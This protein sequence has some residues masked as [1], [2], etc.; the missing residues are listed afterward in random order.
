MKH[1][2]KFSEKSPFIASPERG[3]GPPSGGGGVYKSSATADTLIPNS[4]FK[5]SHLDKFPKILY[6][7][8]KTEVQKMKKKILSVILSVAMAAVSMGSI[9]ATASAESSGVLVIGDSVAKGTYT[10]TVSKSLGKSLTDESSE[11]YT[12]ADILSLVETDK[13]KTEISQ[14]D[15]IIIAAGSN[16][17]INPVMEV[18]GKLGYKTLAE[19]SEKI[20]SSP[21]VKQL[22]SKLAMDSLTIS[23]NIEEIYESVQK[24][25]PTAKIVVQNLYNPLS[26]D[27]SKMTFSLSMANTNLQADVLRNI[28]DTISKLKGAYVSD[29]STLFANHADLYTNC[30]NLD[31]SLNAKGE[32]AAATEI[33]SVLGFDGKS[34][35]IQNNFSSLTKDEKKDLIQKNPDEV[36]KIEKHLTAGMGDVTGDGSVDSKDAVKILVYY[37]NTLA[38]VPD[39]INMSIADLNFDEKCDAS[40]A[41]L[42]LRFYA[43]KLVDSNITMVDFLNKNIK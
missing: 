14:N 32:I 19:A 33:L 11:S 1:L 26:V 3:G 37:A 10:E 13:L 12:T 36:K 28:N 16:D 9:G 34:E 18:V 22:Y 40:D 27:V 7:I 6:N 43:E 4:S 41:V 30:D 42:V 5:K 17:I 38:G 29:L 31:A 25:N 35:N 39:S 2:C 20:T 23:D 21:E 15:V 8:E 24:T